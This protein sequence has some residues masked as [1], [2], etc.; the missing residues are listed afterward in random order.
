MMSLTRR[1]SALITLA[2]LARAENNFI[3]PPDGGP[4]G[5]LVGNSDLEFT[6]GD[7]LHLQWTTD[8]TT[9]VTLIAF[10]GPRAPQTFFYNLTLFSNA[11]DPI[12]TS[13][14]W[15]IS[16]LNPADPNYV[17]A[18]IHFLLWTGFEDSS[19]NSKYIHIKRASDR[20]TSSSTSS[21]VSL[22]S[23]GQPSPTSVSSSSRSSTPSSS[24]PEDSRSGSSGEEALK[25]GLG[26]GV[27]VA[28][29]L[30]GLVGYYFFRRAS[31]KKVGSAG[32]E[33]VPVKGA[34]P[35]NE[36]D[37]KVTRSVHE[38]YGVEA[39]Q[40]GRHEAYGREIHEAP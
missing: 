24:P 16:P 19:F 15:T 3:F 13:F 28:F 23:S 5:V 18:P 32:S 35:V 26:V 10:Q 37:G 34:E 1:I 14:D 6:L 2:L 9:P 17:T 22:S 20:P 12:P 31:R 4:P 40:L 25:I 11:Q 39:R 30:G 33:V 7:T 38:V 29:M 36:L 8:S 27:S 21:D